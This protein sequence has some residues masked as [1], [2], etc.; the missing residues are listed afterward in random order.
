MYIRC[1]RFLAS[2]S[3]YTQLYMYEM[4]LKIIEQEISWESEDT[5]ICVAVCYFEID[6]RYICSFQIIK[7]CF[8]HLDT[9]IYKHIYP[10]KN[11]FI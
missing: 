11:H 6:Y 10:W 7:T 8:A 5:E 1:D 2:H 9:N 4:H 3:I